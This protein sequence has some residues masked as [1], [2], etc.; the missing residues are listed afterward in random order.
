M[1]KIK[2][3]DVVHLW[4]L[5]VF[6]LV[7]QIQEYSSGRSSPLPPPTRRFHLSRRNSSRRLSCQLVST[8]VHSVLLSGIGW[9]AARHFRRSFNDLA[10]LT[11]NG[12]DK[13]QE[14][15]LGMKKMIKF[16]GILWQTDFLTFW[17][18][19]KYFDILKIFQACRPSTDRCFITIRRNWRE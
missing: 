3:W 5:T 18:I 16:L 11:M 1:Y 2:K 4:L 13:Q 8:A 6:P 15:G 12:A 14:N 7:L 9:N 17:N 10:L 19:F